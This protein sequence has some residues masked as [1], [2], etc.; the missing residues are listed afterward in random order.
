MLFHCI[1]LLNL[2]LYAYYNLKPQINQDNY[3]LSQTQRTAIKFTKTSFYNTTNCHWCEL[4][5]SSLNKYGLDN[6]LKLFLIVFIS[7]NIWTGLQT[8]VQPNHNTV[9][10]KSHHIRLSRTPIALWNLPTLSPSF[11][12][13]TGQ[14]VL[15]THRKNDFLL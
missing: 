11:S 2:Y 1:F 4:L 10:N 14:P 7:F 6:M 3:I 15:R 12:R 8:A 9:E 13:E 5:Y